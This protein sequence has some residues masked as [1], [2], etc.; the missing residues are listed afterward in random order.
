MAE[1]R[2]LLEAESSH[3]EPDMR[4]R[5]QTAHRSDIRPLARPYT[6]KLGQQLDQALKCL[7]LEGVSDSN[8]YKR[9]AVRKNIHGNRSSLPPAVL[10]SHAFVHSHLYAHRLKTLLT[11]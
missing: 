7:R 6:T 4:P 11:A 3:S 1:Q 2:H 5:K 8:Y 9:H 10:S